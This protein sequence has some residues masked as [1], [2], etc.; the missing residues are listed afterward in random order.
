[1]KMEVVIIGA[2]IAGISAAKLLKGNGI[3]CV[4]LEASN[5]IGGRARSKKISHNQWFD[6]GC[7]YLHEGHLNPFVGIAKDF[8]FL[9][10]IKSGNMFQAKNTK[11]YEAHKK[12]PNYILKKFISAELDLKI[13]M[14][15]SNKGVLDQKASEYINLK[16]K[17]GPI[18]W[19]LLANNNA[20][21]PDQISLA[22]IQATKD[23]PDYPVPR[24]LGN[25][26]QS[27]GADIPV[28]LNTKVIEVTKSSDYYLIK[29]ANETF[30]TKKVLVTV[31]TG[32]LASSNIRFSPEM[33]DFKLEAINNLPMGVL[34]K[35]GISFESNT[36]D[37][38]QAGWYVTFPNPTKK[39]DC[40]IGSFEL[41][42]SS[43]QT[44]TIFAG[45]K[46]GKSLEE[47]GVEEMY[48][49]GL[50]K[51]QAVFGKQVVKKVENS[52]TTSWSKDEFTLGSY[53]YAKPGGHHFR[54]ILSRPVN[55][56][57]FFA[58]E[59]TSSEHYGTCHGAYLSGVRAAKQIVFSI[60]CNR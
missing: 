53:S 2:G 27:W 44:V 38:R 11:L 47:K 23:G 9:V 49:Y 7:S 55:D 3:D 51:V 21:D 52:I 15:S 4:L 50:S 43:S 31:S 39:N 8:N 33:P 10:D 16:S 12:A 41:C 56:E 26:I 14:N 42:A 60:N 46:I 22:D 54:E 17:F 36:F 48:D 18:F 40:R 6:L 30:T 32:I 25:L 24:G 57:I 45:G 1:M 34:N 37:D 13:K 35:I 29:T 58:G 59:A 5:A 20:A 19:H 28:K